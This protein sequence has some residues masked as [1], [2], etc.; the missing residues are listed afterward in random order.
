MTDNDALVRAAFPVLGSQGAKVDWQFVADHGK[1]AQ[2]NHYQ[3]VER[4]AQ[5]GGLSWCELA[6]VIEN[7]EYKN[8]DT[9]DAIVAVRS[10]EAEYLAALRSTPQAK[11]LDLPAQD[12]VEA[13]AVAVAQSTPQPGAVV[14]QCLAELGDAEPLVVSKEDDG[15]AVRTLS[16]WRLLHPAGDD[17]LRE[18]NARLRGA[19]RDASVSLCWAA[20]QMKGNC[21]GGAVDAVNLA[22]GNAS[23]V[24]ALTGRQG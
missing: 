9:N 7:R 20:R 15:W 2:R 6:A 19:L 11:S 10:A 23:S 22:A 13:V 14:N 24:A 5:R 17:A 12:E 16:A 4:L 21:N 18:E 3:T 1:Q 8:M